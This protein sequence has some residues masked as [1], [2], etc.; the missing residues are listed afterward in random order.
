MLVAN[1][2]QVR[3]DGADSPMPGLLARRYAEM[4][5]TDIRYV[6]KPHPLI[7]Q[8][9]RA[10]VHGMVVPSLA[11]PSLAVP[12]LALMYHRLATPL[13]HHACCWAQLAA[14][15]LPEGARVAAVGDS[16]HHDVLGAVRNGIDS[17]LVC[18]GVHSATLGVPQAGAELPSPERLAA[19]IDG[20][21]QESGGSRPTHIVAAFRHG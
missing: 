9:C 12:S 14:A 1:P 3:P 19:L 20:F 8:A 13:I 10:K 7:Y 4:G 6:G 11:V 18:S 21:A 15:G 5:A 17:V 16:L 2:D